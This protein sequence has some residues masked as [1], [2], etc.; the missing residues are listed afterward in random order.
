[1]TVTTSINYKEYQADGIA[2]VYAIPFLLLNSN[3]LQVF[4]NN[5]LITTGFYLKGIGNPISEITFITPPRGKLLLQ[6]NIVLLRETDYQENGDLLAHTI[7]RDF[8]RLYL[9]LQGATQNNNKN[10]RV[11]DAEGILALPYAL[12]RA[13]KLLAFDNQGQPLLINTISGS[14]LELTK[15]LAD[16]SQAA[17]GAG[18]IGYNQLVA[19]PPDTLGNTLTKILQTVPKITVA[20]N[21]PDDSQGIEGEIWFEL[22][23]E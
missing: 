17:K 12:E 10:V 19:Y 6:R 20:N 15:D 23:E 21:N 3:D 22:E 2:S 18:M 13:D 4:I 5:N 8:D 16:K 1:M 14:T 11:P 7:N 9:A